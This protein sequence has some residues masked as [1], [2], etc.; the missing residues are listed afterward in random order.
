MIIIF[1]ALV[2]SD[3]EQK[4]IVLGGVEGDPVKINELV[5]KHYRTYG[6]INNR[7]AFNSFVVK[8]KLTFLGV[9]PVDVT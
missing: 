1:H 4:S 7:Q 3:Q 5:Q 2:G 9:S 6:A 8:N